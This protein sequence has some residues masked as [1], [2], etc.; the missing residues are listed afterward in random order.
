M[1]S[2]W[3]AMLLLLCKFEITTR[4]WW[5]TLKPFNCIEAATHRLRGIR[6][7]HSENDIRLGSLG[8]TSSNEGSQSSVTKNMHSYS[9][10]ALSSH[11]LFWQGLQSDILQSLFLVQSGQFVV[12]NRD[13]QEPSGHDALSIC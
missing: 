5:T 7:F 13:A 8:R 12:N 1:S 4:A 2:S 10:V 11:Q 6:D 3:I 9:F